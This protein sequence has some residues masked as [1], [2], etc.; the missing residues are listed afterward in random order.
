MSTWRIRAFL[1]LALAF[2]VSCY[3]SWQ[4]FRY[5]TSGRTAEA[6]FGRVYD[7]TRG[8][9]SEKVRIAEFEFTDQ[10]GLSRKHEEE[11]TEGWQPPADVKL[12]VEY[13]P[14]KLGA[15]RLAGGHAYLALIV[16]AVTFGAGTFLA[17]KW[18]REATQPIRRTR[19]SRR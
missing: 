14:G 6:T 7:T 8:R 15:T 9:Y 13:L 4:E 16:V 10:E 19:V 12:T 1:F 2:L 17:I 5:L 18:G 3:L 11:V